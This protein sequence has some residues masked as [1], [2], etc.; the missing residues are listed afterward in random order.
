MNANAIL[1]SRFE[2]DFFLKI[3]SKNDGNCICE[4]VYSKTLLFGNI[5][6]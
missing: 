5:I 3:I 1:A 2:A 6:A 4:T